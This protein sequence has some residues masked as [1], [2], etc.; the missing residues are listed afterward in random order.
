M[1]KVKCFIFEISWKSEAEGRC[2][3]IVTANKED[4]A[5]EE[6]KRSKW[7]KNLKGDEKFNFN[8]TINVCFLP[9]LGFGEELED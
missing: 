2:T 8:K 5:I 9:C 1:K 4:E 3:C 7:G 6:I